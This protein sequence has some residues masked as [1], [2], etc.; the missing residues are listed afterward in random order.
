MYQSRVP[1]DMKLESTTKTSEKKDG[2][3]QI[4]RGMIA[5]LANFHSRSTKRAR[6]ATDPEIMPA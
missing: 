3:V 4:L 6:S 2:A 1:N 5:G